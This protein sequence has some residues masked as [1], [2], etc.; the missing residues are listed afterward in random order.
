V[1]T[2]D[3]TEWSHGPSNS[4]T[5][6]NTRLDDRKPQ[7][8]SLNDSV[9][10]GTGR[11]EATVPMTQWGLEISN[12]TTLSHDNENFKS[13][14]RNTPQSLTR[15]AQPK[16]HDARPSPWPLRW[17]SKERALSW[18][19][20]TPSTYNLWCYCP[21]WARAQS[22]SPQVRLESTKKATPY[23]G[24]TLKSTRLRCGPRVTHEV[25]GLTMAMQADGSSLGPRVTHVLTSRYNCQD[26]VCQPSHA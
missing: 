11:Y 13:F 24:R 12:W 1:R 10:H 17:T 25:R 22:V 5:Q 3:W 4:K 6:E 14:T 2:S 19:N 20:L 7:F 15:P 18:Y 16:N 26:K 8:W 21:G 23:D 9:E